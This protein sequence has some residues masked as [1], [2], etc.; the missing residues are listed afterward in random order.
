MEIKNFV[1]NV[2]K[3][4]L[5]TKLLSLIGTR[6]SDNISILFLNKMVL[7]PGYKQSLYN[8]PIFP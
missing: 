3:F 8:S 1:T 2:S 6:G 7:N 5:K 4:I